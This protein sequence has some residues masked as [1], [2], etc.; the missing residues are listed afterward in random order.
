MAKNKATSAGRVVA[1]TGASEYLGRRLVEH[2]REHPGYRKICVIDVRQPACA[3]G[4]KTVFCPVDL[5]MPE[6]GRELA[7]IFKKHKVDTLVHLA[8]LSHPLQDVSYAHELQ[9][10]GTLHLL[11]GASAARVAKVVMLGDTKS[12][13]ARPDNPNFLRE[14]D[15]LRG[16][17]HSPLV[18]DLVEVEKQLAEFSRKHPRVCCTVLRMGNILSREVDG[19]IP[20]LLAGSTVPVVMGYDPLMQF[21]HHD[22]ALAAIK[23]AVA[24]EHRGAYNITS[25]GVMPLST[26]IR[27]GGRLCLPIPHCLWERFGSL[28]WAFQVQDIPPSLLPYLRYLFVADGELA[29]KKLR[30]TPRHSS[31]E[32]LVEFYRQARLQSAGLPPED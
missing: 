29:R 22:D 26:A 20:R 16:V 17:N 6:A 10:I 12:Y 18:S 11:N 25:N 3:T 5:T 30:F 15:P 31:R 13:G 28:L 7:G 21:L 14:S 8:F 1:V 2:L 4:P 9:V 19:F 23:L 32:T 24:G 27:M